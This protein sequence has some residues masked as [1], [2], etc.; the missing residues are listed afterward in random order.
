MNF[1]QAKNIFEHAL[2]AE[3]RGQ[4]GINDGLWALINTYQPH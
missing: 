1:Q 3:K 4:N 2:T